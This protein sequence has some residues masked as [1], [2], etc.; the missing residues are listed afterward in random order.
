M[1]GQQF[2]T[3]G[4]LMDTAGLNRILSLDN[5]RGL[6]KVEAGILWDDLVGGLRQLQI[7]ATQRW[8]VV[9]KQ[10]GAD[11]LSIGGALAANGHGRGLQYAP[12][13]QDVESLELVVQQL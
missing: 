12:I 11:R 6:V 7:G 1:G 8:S 4:V 5:E 13:V 9:Q 2:L 3:G 10:T